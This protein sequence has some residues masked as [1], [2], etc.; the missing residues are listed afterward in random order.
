MV[1]DVDHLIAGQIKAIGCP[2]KFTGASPASNRGAPVLGQHTS[3]VLN[4]YGY[5]AHDIQ[6]LVKTGIAL[7]G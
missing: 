1:M 4:E 2:I 5:S 3:E 7:Q 6:E